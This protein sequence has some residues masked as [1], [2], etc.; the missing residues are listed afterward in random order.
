MKIDGNLPATQSA[1]VIS[2]FGKPDVLQYK[3]RL[4]IPE[5]AENEVLV[6][7]AYSSVNPV[8]YKTRQGKGW[9]AEAI[10]KE[11][12][13]RN[14]FAILGFD[15]SGVVVKTNS[16]KVAIGDRVAALTYN[17]GCYAQYNTIEEKYI[18]KLPENISLEQAGALPCVG[19]TAYQVVQFADIKPNEH[20]VLNA[21][22]GGVGHIALQLLMKKVENENVKLSLICSEDKYEKIQKLINVDKLENWIDYTKYGEDDAFPNLDADLFLDF[23]GGDAGVKG[24]DV[25]KKEGRVVVLPSIWVDKLKEAGE[26]R[27]LTVEGFKSNPNGE[28][29][30]EIL[31][32]VGD[33]EISLE[34][35]SVYPLSKTKEAHEEVQKGD[36]FGKIILEIEQ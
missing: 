30:F 26:S 5:L 2:E 20:V 32:L 18:T 29:L 35:Q 1:V 13:S 36:T 10:K 23:V 9:G 11:K 21:P 17:G 16:N 33:K 25:L 15:L 31:K 34:I 3:D 7:V 14:E 28:D 12:F 22:A 27:N 6:K 19:I 4:P 24:L 8:D